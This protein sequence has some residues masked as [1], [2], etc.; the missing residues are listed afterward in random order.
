MS[1]HSLHANYTNNVA[2][3][4]L[5][6]KKWCRCKTALYTAITSPS[7]HSI[8]PIPTP[9]D[10]ALPTLCHAHALPPGHWLSS[11]AVTVAHRVMKRST[12]H[13][14]IPVMQEDRFGT[15]QSRKPGFTLLLQG[16]HVW[17]SMITLSSLKIIISMGKE[18]FHIGGVFKLKSISI[19]FLVF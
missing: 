8:S 4:T 7:S 14:S 5:K 10:V 16:N 3:G 11:C 17:Y 13:G 18:T 12:T 2:E 19:S 1:R 9:F 15:T 6:C